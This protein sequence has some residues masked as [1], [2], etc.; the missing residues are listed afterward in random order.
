MNRLVLFLLFCFGSFL[1][2]SQGDIKLLL[3]QAGSTNSLRNQDIRALS[4]EEISKLGPVNNGYTLLNTSTGCLNYFFN[5]NWF[6]LCGNCI[7]KY[8]VPHISKITALAF[9]VQLEFADTFRYAAILFPDSDITMTFDRKIILHTPANREKDGVHRLKLINLNETCTNKPAL[10]TFIN[11]PAVD[12][13][14]KL[15]KALPIISTGAHLWLTEPLATDLKDEKVCLRI[16]NRSY[17]NWQSLNTDP[18]GKGLAKIYYTKK[19]CPAG[20]K[21]PSVNEAEDLVAFSRQEKI[22]DKFVLGKAGYVVTRK[23]K[24]EEPTDEK[25]V[26]MLSDSDHPEAFETLLLTSDDIRIARLPR[27]VYV[28]VLCVSE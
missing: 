27:E 25:F 9:G 26:F 22:F 20:F 23:D 24:R 8:G 6:E 1:A 17:Y 12:K 7:P 2:H 13:S 19:V 21:I 11:F 4:A 10:D 15:D 14:K 28:R 18:Y 5:T 3:N 16:N